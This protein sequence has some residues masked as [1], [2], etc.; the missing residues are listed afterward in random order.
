ML[1][2]GVV[3]REYAKFVY[4]SIDRRVKR[5]YSC[6]LHHEQV[7]KEACGRCPGQESGVLRP[8][9]KIVFLGHDVI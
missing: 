2:Y 9:T 6:G 7:D 3:F 8:S 5:S 4:L 1:I